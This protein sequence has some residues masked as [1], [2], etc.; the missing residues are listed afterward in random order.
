MLP[1]LAGAIGLG[2]TLVNAL[3]TVVAI[4]LVDVSTHNLAFQLGS[5]GAKLGEASTPTKS[6]AR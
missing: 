2:V 6:N 4:F 3:T 1:N 5:C